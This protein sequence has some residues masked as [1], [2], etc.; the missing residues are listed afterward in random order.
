[1]LLPLFP[2]RILDK[3]G[4]MLPGKVIWAG[5]EDQYRAFVGSTGSSLASKRKIYQSEKR[6]VMVKTTQ[7]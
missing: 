5:P 3:N 1:M 4:Q 7:A 6:K 2:S